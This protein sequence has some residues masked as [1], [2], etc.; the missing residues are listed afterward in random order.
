MEA[1]NLYFMKNLVKFIVCYS[2]IHPRF[3]FKSQVSLRKMIKTL[4]SKA[5]ILKLIA[6]SQ[7]EKT[8]LTTSLTLSMLMEIALPILNL[9]HKLMMDPW[10]L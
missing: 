2:G 3:L 5:D 6:P 7:L 1:Y 4:L 8:Q 10:F 9:F